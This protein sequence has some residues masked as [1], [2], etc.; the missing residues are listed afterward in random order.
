MLTIIST[1]STIEIV[2]QTNKLLK[3]TAKTT[4]L[5]TAKKLE[6]ITEPLNVFPDEPDFQ[7]RFYCYE[8]ENGLILVEGETTNDWFFSDRNSIE[9]CGTDIVIDCN[10]CFRY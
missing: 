10:R 4:K 3:M 2:N 9:A 7:S 5:L 1:Q 6:V 8:F